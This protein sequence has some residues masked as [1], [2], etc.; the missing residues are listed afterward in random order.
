VGVQ[1]EGR[2]SAGT[3][4]AAEGAGTAGRPTGGHSLRRREV[5]LAG[6]LGA[7]L[8]AGAVTVGLGLG[9]AATGAAG[10][11]AAPRFQ[12][13]VSYDA[14]LPSV[15]GVEVTTVLPHVRAAVV[16]ADAATLR[17]LAARPGVRGISQDQRLTLEGRVSIAGGSFASDGLGG[18]AGYSGAGAGVRVAVVDTGVSDT[19][20]LSRGSGRL[21]DGVDTRAVADGGAPVTTGVFDDGEGHGTFMASVVAG[22]AV[23]GSQGRPVGVAPGATVVVVRVA[24]AEG[25]TSLSQVVAGLDWVAAHR[26]SVDVMSLALSAARPEGVTAYGSDPL[27]DAVAA[28]Q[29][30]GVTTVVASGNVAGVVSDPGFLPQVIT[31]G[32]A[33]VAS[34]TVSANSGSDDVNGVAKPDLVANGT[35][36]FGVVPADSVVARE[37]PGSNLVGDLWRGSGTSQATAVTSGAAAL[38]LARYPQ[39]TPDQV[40][41]SLRTAARPLPDPRAGKGLLRATRLLV[42]GPDG[43]DASGNDLTGE[44][45]FDELTW[46]ANSWSANSWSANSWSAN[47]WSANSWSANSWSANSWSANSWS[48]NSWSAADW[49]DGSGS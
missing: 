25:N 20:A 37:H 34:G 10:P 44:S 13:V 29:A 1:G 18:N 4:A 36:V 5:G 17:V 31:V 28:V 42:S 6:A 16:R 22:G 24:D 26:S 7:L 9:D 2:V 19:S 46:A 39:A 3:S 11:A 14:A 35:S 40:K 27:T 15:P 43:T 38:L 21:V 8:T 12:A 45:G 30:A 49:N 48:A 47:S 33:N 32:A 23:P 41:A